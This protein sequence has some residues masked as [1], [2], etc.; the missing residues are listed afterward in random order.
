MINLLLMEMWAQI[1]LYVT[2]G[3][4]LVFIVLIFAI[5]P[6][7]T[8]FSKGK[9]KVEIALAKGK[10]LFDKREALKEKV[11]KRE[12]DRAVKFRGR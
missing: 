9:V 1:V 11:V 5:V 2:L 3:L 6:T 8:Y 10:H 7:K 12:I 4:L